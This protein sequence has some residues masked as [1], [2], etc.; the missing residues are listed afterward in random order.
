MSFRSLLISTLAALLLLNG[1]PAAAADLAVPQHIDASALR[2]SLERDAALYLLRAAFQLLDQSTVPGLLLADGHRMQIKGEDAEF[3][4]E[5]NE[6][7]L[8]EGSYY[9][10]SLKYLVT[11]GGAN[12][13]T[14]R[15][16]DSYDV[17]ALEALEGLQHRW[18]AAV[19]DGSDL[20]PLLVEVDRINSWT[21][22][23]STLT[24]KLDHF[25]TVDELVDQAMQTLEVAGHS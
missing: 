9:I 19:S 3:N 6:N 17:Q 22:G 18:I 13:P 12:W 10:V 14:D 2:R 21:E 11:V 15:S 4:A 5:L 1:P 8:A 25:A 16:A 24:G 7:L 23:L 20:A